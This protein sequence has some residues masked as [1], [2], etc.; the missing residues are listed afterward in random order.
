MKLDNLKE[1]AHFAAR[2]TVPSA[3]Y[4]IDKVNKAFAGELE[5]VAGSINLFMKN[6]YDIYEI[7]VEEVDN[8]VPK[9]VTSLIS[10]IAE[11]KQVRDGQKA[12]FKTRQPIGRQRAKKFLTRVGIDGVYETFRLDVGE[13]EVPTF[14]IGEGIAIDF[15][16]MVQGLDSLED[17]INIVTEDMTDGIYGEIQKALQSAIDETN[18]LLP[19]TNHV[20][21]DTFD[22]DA[23]FSLITIAKAYGQGAVIF[24]P[25]EFIA[26]MGPDLIVASGQN[27]QPIVPQADIDSIHK[28]GYISMFRGTPLV[29]IPQ[30]FVDSSNTE[31]WIDPQT[32][33]VLPTG[34]EKIVK[35]VL[36]GDTQIY[37]NVNRDRSIEIMLYRKVGVGILAYHNWCAYK[38]T[39]IAQTYQG[40]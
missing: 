10:E 26:S 5:K 9:K 15:S 11:V 30:T 27:Y 22:A 4:N 16:R 38:N 3:D 33:Y 12:V 24:A 17:L 1:L 13:F 18:P 36:E 31:T 19:A 7:I 25:P 2:G 39:S 8:L 21:S 32:A 6:R 40:S 28:T 37:D 34:G 14:A 35:V 29:E 20:I 23:M